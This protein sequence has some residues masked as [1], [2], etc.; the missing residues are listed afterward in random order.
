[1]DKPVYQAYRVLIDTWWNVNLTNTWSTGWWVVVLIDTWWNV[2]PSILTIVLF[3]LVLIDTWWNVNEWLTAYNEHSASVLIDTWWN[4]NIN[5]E[6]PPEWLVA[7]L[8][9]TWWNVNEKS[10]ICSVQLFHSF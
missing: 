5:V 2:N 10:Q 4:V 1:M 3:V 7:V 6:E 8:I 9:D